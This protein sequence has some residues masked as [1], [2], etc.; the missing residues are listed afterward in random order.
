[1]TYRELFEKL[2]TLTE[3]QLNC[4]LTVELGPED[5]C[6][7]AELRIA[8]SEHDSLDENHPIIFVE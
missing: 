4:D 7:P 3:S 1:M 2:G 8:G 6:Y 5:E